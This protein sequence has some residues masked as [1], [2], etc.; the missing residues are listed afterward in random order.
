MNHGTSWLTSQTLK[1]K[2]YKA[3]LKYDLEISLLG[4]HLKETESLFWRDIYN[5]TFISKLFKIAKIGKQPKYLWVS[6]WN[7]C[8]Y[9]V[10]YYS[11]IKKK[12]HHFL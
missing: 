1:D 5:S 12:L 11:T 7:A 2:N 6:E 8:V 3:E 10:E 9:T 4:I